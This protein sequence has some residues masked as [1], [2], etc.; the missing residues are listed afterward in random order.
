M[1]FFYFLS[2]LCEEWLEQFA[3]VVVE[4]RKHLPVDVEVKVLIAAQRVA[5][6]RGRPQVGA[7]TPLSYTT[8]DESNGGGALAHRDPHKNPTPQ[9]AVAL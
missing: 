9:P 5:K 6:E 8:Q 3:R 4:L 7:A 1:Y 2:C